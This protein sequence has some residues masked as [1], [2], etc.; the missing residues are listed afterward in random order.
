MINKIKNLNNMLEKAIV[1]ASDYAENNKGIKINEDSDDY[2]VIAKQI[3]EIGK[4]SEEILNIL[5]KC[6]K[7]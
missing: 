7:K 6:V 2:K 3:E 5:K 1:S 4:E